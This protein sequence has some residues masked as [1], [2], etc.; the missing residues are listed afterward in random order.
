MKDLF[1]VGRS[2]KQVLDAERLHPGGDQYTL[3]LSYAYPAAGSAAAVSA[4]LVEMCGK[5]QDLNIR[6]H[7]DGDGVTA[8]RY[9]GAPEP[10][11]VRLLEADDAAWRERFAY[12]R[13]FPALWDAP[14]YEFFVQARPVADGGGVRV[15]A[16]IHHAVMDGTG[17]A[18][19][20]KRIGKALAG[21]PVEP[22]SARLQ[23]LAAHDAAYEASPR[24]AEDKAYWEAALPGTG[25]FPE[26]ICGEDDA[27]AS[28]LF[29]LDADL[30]RRLE[31]YRKAHL[32]G[33]STFRFALALLG[34]Y[35]C[36]RYDS[37]AVPVATGLS[38]RRE[39]EP[40][41]AG[42]LSMLVDVVVVN[43][44]RDDALDFA[45]WARRVDD[46][47][48]RSVKHGRY[49]AEAL[50]GSLT[51][52]GEDVSRL[53]NFCV[54]SNS[55]PAADF[56]MQLEEEK[57]AAFG[58]IFRVNLFR[59]DG[60]GLQS[61]HI[62]HRLSAFTRQDIVF[63]REGI[64]AMLEALVAAPDT[65]VGRLPIVGDAERRMLL[66]DFQ[67]PP[68][69][70]EPGVT[71]VHALRRAAAA[72]PDHIALKD[73]N[74]TLTYAELDRMTDRLAVLLDRR[75]PV[76]GRFVALGL[77]RSNAFA[78]A[79]YAVLKAGGAYLPLDPEYPRERVEYMLAD[80]RSAFLITDSRAPAGQ[81]GLQVEGGEVLDLDALTAEAE[82]AEA[83]PL[84]EPP[85]EGDP[86]YIIYT[87][88][89]TGNPKGVVVSHRALSALVRWNVELFDLGTESRVGLHS[90]FSFDAAVM[91]LFPPL[92]AGAQLH[93][94]GE[95]VR[96]D[97]AAFYQY[98]RD[99]GI[100][101]IF[102]TTQICVE[103]LRQYELP[104]RTI[105]TG[106][107]KLKVVPKHRGRLYNCYGPTECTV[108]STGHLLDAE[109]GYR[110][111]PIGKPMAGVLH[112][113]LDRNG[114][115]LPVG[116]PG[117]LCLAGEQTAD[118]Y[119]G[120]EE[121]TAKVFVRN[122]HAASPA[123]G[124]MYRTGDLAV[125]N[126]DGEVE[127]MGRFD[128]Q[129]KLR[130]FRIELGEI[131]TAML[132][133]PGVTTAMAVVRGDVLA[134]YFMSERDVDDEEMRGTL[135]ARL[136]EYMVPSGFMRLAA[137]PMT[138]GGKVDRKKLPPLTLPN[139]EAK[140]A[141]E[142]TGSVDCQSGG[143]C[144]RQPRLWG[145]HQPVSGRNELPRRYPNRRPAGGGNRGFV[146]RQRPD[147][148]QNR[149]RHRGAGIA[150]RS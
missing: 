108:I 54:V 64:A 150:G 114:E 124:L 5:Y 21:A 1:P 24:F 58:L 20:G 46:I 43:I 140:P 100:T 87:S 119:W 96:F 79:V 105:C 17:L 117:E 59:D 15:W 23:E 132:S 120:R 61:L 34:A 129:V 94:L 128:D 76:R 16:K 33:L 110:N 74:G 57:S 3:R 30:T 107:E 116:C 136:P 70:A 142:R 99:E 19:F 4:A 109:R 82:K 93:V 122:P 36:R 14:L 103:F 84:P 73:D 71:F 11:R 8:R 45:G 83:A 44:R 139:K 125:W 29:A 69:A 68:H 56:D 25:D 97:P 91:G 32:P 28:S 101:D 137:M 88:G 147:A 89:S 77:S 66:G 138:P 65:P 121:Q 26:S 49:P 12:D 146:E 60:K 145:G 48:S 52:R 47:F 40:E 22:V 113:I 2:Q 55:L 6:F 62:V 13:P 143:R 81:W 123:E 10:E 90:T 131:E 67:V 149:G 72:Y 86:A 53:R 18:I 37:D 38:G 144:Y 85:A 9:V 134:G 115:L 27:S 127:Y 51:E 31:E 148:R 80:S 102:L 130:G 78:A 106:G 111:I 135:A 95:K 112:Y 104:I 39:L 35:L 50:A 63:M 118:G 92:T 141:R 42:V 133:V 98:A 7:L 126:R 41:P 75:G